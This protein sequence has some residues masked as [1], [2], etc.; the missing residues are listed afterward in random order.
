MK[1][2][3]VLIADDDR[4]FA[5]SLGQLIELKGN[6]SQVVFSGQSAVKEFNKNDFDIC[7]IDIKMPDMN[8]VETFMAIRKLKHDA[9]IILMTGY[10]ME[11]ISDAIDSDGMVVLHKPIKMEVI[12][13]IID[14][15][16]KDSFSYYGLGAQHHYLEKQ[17][18]K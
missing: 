14:S 12:F 2:V 11:D 9:R 17:T 6:I 8:G 15:I 3:H 13:S 5:E 18:K 10:S 16:Q 7:F 4:D 1:S